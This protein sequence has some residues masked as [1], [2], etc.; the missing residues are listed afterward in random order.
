MKGPENETAGQTGIWHGGN[1]ASSNAC[2][3]DSTSMVAGASKLRAY[4]VD[5]W[6]CV[7]E[8]RA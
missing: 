8:V 6:H 1:V 7:V 4:T 2:L 5:L 3:S